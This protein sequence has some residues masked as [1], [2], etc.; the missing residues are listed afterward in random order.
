[1]KTVRMSGDNRF[2]KWVK[3]SYRN[4]DATASDEDM[5]ESGSSMSESG[6]SITDPNQQQLNLVENFYDENGALTR[7]DTSDWPTATSTNKKRYN[8]VGGKTRK[9][10][11][12]RKR[13]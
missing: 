8:E 1:M 4:K 2:V 3:G 9:K 10:L 5:S 6:S 7:Q 11:L 13:K 12:K